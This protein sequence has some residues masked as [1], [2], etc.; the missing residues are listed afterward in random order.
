MHEE[1]VEKMEKLVY[2]VLVALLVLRF[3]TVGSEGNKA[4]NGTCKCKYF[5]AADKY[6]FYDNHCHL[7]Y[8]PTFRLHELPKYPHD[9]V[10]RLVCHCQCQKIFK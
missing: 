4:S 8:R 6:E 2:L 1:T 3:T 9:P 7:G 5:Y 10:S